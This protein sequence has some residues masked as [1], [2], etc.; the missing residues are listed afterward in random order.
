[1]N[2]LSYDRCAYAEAVTQSAAPINFL[3]DPVQ[4]EHCSQCR[5]ELGIVGGTAVSRVNGNLVDLEN[6]LI[7][8][9]RPGTQCSSLMFSPVRPGESLQ[10]I[11]QY[12]STCY[13]KIDTDL[14]HLPKCQFQSFPAVQIPPA[15]APFECPKKR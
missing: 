14:T 10:G 11:G 13:P 6:N 9:D 3:L 1:M 4:Y 2:R 7:G 15:P 8:L 5:P 12:K